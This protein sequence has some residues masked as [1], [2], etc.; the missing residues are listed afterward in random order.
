MFGPLLRDAFSFT[1]GDQVWKAKRKACA[2]GFY[3]DKLIGM[4]EIFKDVLSDSFE[5]WRQ[6]IIAQTQEN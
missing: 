2:H 5:E 3:K 4:I 1:S 6:D